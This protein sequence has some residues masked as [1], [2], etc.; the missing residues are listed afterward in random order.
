MAVLENLVGTL[1]PA[2]EWLQA[3]KSLAI[4]INLVL[5]LLSGYSPLRLSI[6][7]PFQTQVKDSLLKSNTM[8]LWYS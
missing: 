3:C 2:S 6:H 5:T 4:L 1:L 8:G 7:N